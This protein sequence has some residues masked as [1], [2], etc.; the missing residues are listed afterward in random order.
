MG[1]DRS[2]H[3]EPFVQLAGLDD[4][5]ALIAWGG[6]WFR[7]ADDGRGQRIV[8]DADLAGVD[9]GRTGSIGVRSEPYGAA[10]VRAY[11]PDGAVAAQARTDEANHVWLRGLRASTTYRYEV[12]VDGRPWAPRECLRWERLDD[13]HGELRPA[14]RGYDLRFT[15]FPQPGAASTLRFAALG[16]YGFGIQTADEQ[17]AHQRHLAAVLEQLVDADRLDLI[18]TLGDNIYHGEGI[19][20]GG[21]GAE[22]DDW[23]FSYYEPYRFTISRVPVFPSIGN[24]DAAETERSDDRGQVADNHF[25]ELRFHPDVEASRASVSVEGDR[26]AGLFYRFSYGDLVE[27]ACID[28]SEA[29]GF[30]AVRYFDDPQHQPFLERT[31]EPRRA[32][33]G[34][35]LI[36]FGH[37][38]PYCAGPSHRNDD[39]QLRTMIPH[40]RRAGVQVV[41]AGHEHNFQHALDDGLHV[42]V[43]GAGGKLTRGEPPRTRAAHTRSW[44]D[45][46]HV[47]LGEVTDQQ[48]QLRPVG[49]LDEHGE[50]VPFIAHGADGQP[51]EAF[52]LT[53]ATDPPAEGPGGMAG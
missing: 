48:L 5:Q 29:A 27:F 6:F 43:C 42:M 44:A 2:V 31:F 20:M 46:P 35:W 11:G 32:D 15:T 9:A 1:T 52:P 25:T 8:D 53:I 17:G 7:L 37:H 41:L 16:D 23:Y 3:F 49:A 40:Y 34:R 19:S 4:D 28:T 18:V 47:L 10:E 12:L 26:A 36:P 13:Q 30:D 38:P 24:H 21:S 39:A 45:V 50:P 33:R 22:D 14:G 51:D